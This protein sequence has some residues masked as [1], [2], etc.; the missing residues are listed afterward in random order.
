MNASWCWI[1]LALFAQPVADDPTRPQDPAPPAA[2]DASADAQSPPAELDSLAARTADDAIRDLLEASLTMPAGSEVAGRSTTLE[3]VLSL[4]TSR[5]Q[6][7]EAVHAYWQLAAAAAEFRYSWDYLEYVEWVAG[8]L[9]PTNDAAP[10][11]LIAVELAGSRAQLEEARLQFRAAQQELAE[12]LGLAVDQALPLPEDPPHAGSYRT[13][14]A[15]IFADRA[16]PPGVQLIDRLLPLRLAAVR[17]RAE[18]VQA[19]TDVLQPL[20]DAFSA[21]TLAED[22]L[23]VALRELRGQQRAF[24][25]AVQRYNDD[26]ADYALQVAGLATPLD[27]LVGTLIKPR[28]PAPA[29]LPDEVAENAATGP[30]DVARATFEEETA[31]LAE[32]ETEADHPA[33]TDEPPANPFV[34]QPGEVETPE[35]LDSTLLEAPALTP[36]GDA[37]EDEAATLREVRRPTPPD[38][39]LNEALYAA[40]RTLK[41][42]AQTRELSGLLHSA[43]ALPEDE[44]EP[45]S[46]RAALLAAPPL[47]RR[48]VLEAYWAAR[49]EAARLEAIHRA[50]DELTVLEDWVLQRASTEQAGEQ[51]L[52]LQRELR[53]TAAELSEVHAEL[54]RREARLA[55]VLGQP[56]S[57][58]WPRPSTAPHPGAYRLK[59]ATDPLVLAS[60]SLQ[61]ALEEIPALFDIL[62]DRAAETIAA[63]A[64]RAAEAGRYQAGQ[65]NLDG[66]LAA[67]RQQHQATREFL[68]VLE[69]YNLRIAAYALEVL[70]PRIS[71]DGLLSALVLPEL[72]AEPESTPAALESAP[73]AEG[74]L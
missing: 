41:A 19:A 20:A 18:A 33:A 22:A 23:L 58:P 2:I 27:A 64:Q 12:V 73:P 28:A 39:V 45:V 47:Q 31:E 3:E 17:E 25:R 66:L 26:I 44:S 72:A 68:N 14:F 56:L 10:T 65:A 9:A 59:V 52:T 37:D 16:A 5:G 29:A 57:R 74:S 34:D 15:E 49:L 7:R 36:P 60:R 61:R 55:E 6:Q 24:I 54:A 30:D 38:A 67:I 8:V 63:D 1:G 40:L 69:R 71:A 35:E 13:R 21:G 62:Q 32:Q 4:T 51:M 70:P 46:L 53:A 11:G 50:L 42:T 43:N 48:A